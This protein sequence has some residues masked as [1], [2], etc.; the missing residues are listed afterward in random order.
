MINKLT[1]FIIFPVSLMLLSSCFGGGVNQ[2]FNNL[3][4]S[5]L[6]KKEDVATIG[7][8][9]L[10]N[11][12]IFSFLKQKNGRSVVQAWFK[13][14]IV[15]LLLGTSSQ[16]FTAQDSRD[17]YDSNSPEREKSIV[18]ANGIKDRVDIIL[19][20][21][22]NALLFP[23]D[24]KQQYISLGYDNLL[25]YKIKY[26]QN[27]AYEELFNEIYIKDNVAKLLDEFQ[28][29]KVWVTK[30]SKASFAE[31]AISRFETAAAQE[32][33]DK[34]E[35]SIND[36]WANEAKY[37]YLDYLRL[38][39]EDYPHQIDRQ[40]GLSGIVKSTFLK[41][42]P[43]IDEPTLVGLKGYELNDSEYFPEEIK[44]L[45]FDKYIGYDGDPEKKSKGFFEEKGGINEWQM[46]T[47]DNGKKYYVEKS[48]S[49]WVIRV[50]VIREK[51]GDAHE[52]LNWVETEDQAKA[53][54]KDYAETLRALGRKDSIISKAQTYLFEKY[55]LEV[56]DEELWLQ[57]SGEILD[58]KE[59]KQG[60]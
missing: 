33:K 57:I 15:D 39:E 14:T 50:K 7:E 49:I 31:A 60:E 51:F 24:I 23:K 1:K 40:L 6:T 56:F 59:T 2:N 36:A 27:I 41:A 54:N 8:E 34:P 28:P 55:A 20:D 17:R 21:Q 48:D 5:F 43:T 52:E 32:V 16:K 37:R 3:Q 53:L 42:E 29:R 38:G 30:F 18:T 19:K 26:L 4:N 25:E 11:N 13:T 45:L 12:D 44:K 46:L 9:S 10:S 35:K 47:Y 58:N 22:E